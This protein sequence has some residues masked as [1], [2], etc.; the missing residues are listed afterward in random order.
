MKAS[1]LLLLIFCIRAHGQN[2]DAATTDEIAVIKKY[3]RAVNK[4]RSAAQLNFSTSEG[5]LKDSNSRSFYL[6]QTITYKAWYSRDSTLRKITVLGADR[7]FE[8]RPFTEYYFKDAQLVCIHEKYTNASRMGSCGAVEFELLLFF[9]N[10]IRIGLERLNPPNNSFY[11]SCYPLSISD[12]AIFTQL[13][14]VMKT[15]NEKRSA[16]V[17]DP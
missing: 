15:V 3:I 12:K 9:Q 6:P 2:I 14:E 8:G 13:A 7:M 5:H 11:N 10:N 4:E 16:M 1:S 17:A